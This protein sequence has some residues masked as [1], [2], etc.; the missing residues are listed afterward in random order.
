[1]IYELPKLK[2]SYDALE[3]FID[4]R[5]MEIHHSKHHKAYINKL[6]DALKN[7]LDLQEKNLEELLQF[8]DKI[9]V[10]IRTAVRNNA[11]GHFSHSLFWEIMGPNKGG[12][13]VRQAQDGPSGKL[14]DDI[15]KTFGNFQNFKEE[16]SKQANNL[17][18]SGWVWL[19]VDPSTD[20]GQ[21]KIM[22]TSGH[23]NPIMT[24]KKPLMILDVWEHAYYLKYQNRRPEYVEAWWNVVN[25]DYIES[26]YKK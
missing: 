14:A 5:T 23:D 10:E 21:V 20:L 1:M 25:W 24:G 12:E 18:G 19:Y 22:S 9:P 13:S 6:N 17:F 8:L 11:G 4:A 3:P 16:F 26:E 7:Y 2:Y 15:A